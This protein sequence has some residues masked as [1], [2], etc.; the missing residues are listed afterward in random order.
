MKVIIDGIEYVPRE[1]KFKDHN[2]YYTLADWFDMHKG[3]HEYDGI[4]KTIQEWYYGTL[5]KASWCATSVSYALSRMGLLKKTMGRKCENVYV[6]YTQ[7]IATKSAKRIELVLGAE[8]KRGDILIYNWDSGELRADGRKHV[9]IAYKDCKYQLG[10][11]CQSIGGNQDDMI[12]VSEYPFKNLYAV[13][14]PEY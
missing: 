2:G 8:I 10:N 12:K 4:V 13:F 3:V 6:M 9:S 14:R 7:L 5:V 11:L 1:T